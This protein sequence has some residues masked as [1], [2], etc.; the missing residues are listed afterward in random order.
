MVPETW[1]GLREMVSHRLREAGIESFE[2]ETWVLLEWKLGISRADYYMG[3]ETK[4]SAGQ[5]AEIEKVLLQR[6]RRIPLQYLMRTCSFMGYDFYVDENVLIPRQ[7]TEVLVERAVALLRRNGPLQKAGKVLDLCT[8]SGC[9]GISVKLLCPEAEVTVADISSGALAVARRNAENLGAELQYVEGNLFETIT[10]TYD[11]ILS[12][13]P[14]IPTKVID[15]L[16]PEVRDYEPHL[17][18][19]GMEDGLYFY[20]EICREAKNFLNP[21]GRLIFEIGM[22]QGE[23]VKVLMEMQGMEEI[24][25][26]KDLAG[27]DRVV[28]GRRPVPQMKEVAHV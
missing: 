13:P 21:G 19:D 22:E 8:G 7:D 11:F 18:L 23:D 15:G 4:V 10:D 16:M 26:E 28:L 24:T 25:I 14:Y 17:A 27:L 6:E 2:Y 20:R 5:W 9:I 1:K 3:P 12:N